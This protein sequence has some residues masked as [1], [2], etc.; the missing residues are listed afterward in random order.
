MSLTAY[1]LFYSD[2]RKFFMN[3]LQN[4]CKNVG[5]TFLGSGGQNESNSHQLAPNGEKKIFHELDVH[6]L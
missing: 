4:I 6:H 3:S 2:R 5:Q 1:S